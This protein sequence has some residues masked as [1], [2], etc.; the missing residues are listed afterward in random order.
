[1]LPTV[2]GEPALACALFALDEL[3]ARGA[4]AGGGVLLISARGALASAG[5]RPARDAVA[6]G[7]VLLL[8]ARGAFA[9]DGALARGDVGARSAEEAGRPDVLAGGAT[10]PVPRGGVV[11]STAGWLGLSGA[12]GGAFDAAT[13]LTAPGPGT[14]A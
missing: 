1:L 6:G 12:G 5:G 7:G 14:V 2:T 3:P 8:S 10:P 4:V 11:S 13:G 9:S